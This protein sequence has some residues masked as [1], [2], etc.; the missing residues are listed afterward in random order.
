LRKFLLYFVRVLN[1]T[2]F[3]SVATPKLD[4]TG[5]CAGRRWKK[6]ENGES[7]KSA[8]AIYVYPTRLCTHGWLTWLVPKYRGYTSLLF[9]RWRKWN[10]EGQWIFTRCICTNWRSVSILTSFS[11]FELCHF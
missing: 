7:V 10:F 5:V 2:N 11:K 9:W 8:G 1:R 3:P 6:K 4:T